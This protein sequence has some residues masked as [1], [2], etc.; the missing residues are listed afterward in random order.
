MDWD[1]KDFCV[2]SAYSSLSF[3][4]TTEMY[5]CRF[6]FDHNLIIKYH[7]NMSYNFPE[8]YEQ[9]KMFGKLE[10]TI[11]YIRQVRKDCDEFCDE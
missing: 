5:N 6:W 7:L 8:T 3:E 2:L 10:I 9:V 1:Y 4:V 11:E